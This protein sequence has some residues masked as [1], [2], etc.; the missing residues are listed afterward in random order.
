ME[1]L[2]GYQENTVSILK[3]SFVLEYRMPSCDELATATHIRRSKKS[4]DYHQSDGW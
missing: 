1:R 2:N 4:S 3:T